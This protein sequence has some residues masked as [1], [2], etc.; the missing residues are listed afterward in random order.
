MFVF[1]KGIIENKIFNIGHLQNA[2]Q[3]NIR[4]VASELCEP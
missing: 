3:F 1:R 4:S 2:I